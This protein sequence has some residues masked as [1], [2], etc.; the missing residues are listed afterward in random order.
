MRQVPVNDARK[1]VVL[2][3]HYVWDLRLVV[4]RGKDEVVLGLHWALHS[5]DIPVFVDS[6]ALK[7]FFHKKTTVQV[8]VRHFGNNWLVQLMHFNKY[9]VNL[10]L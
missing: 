9:M 7:R 2:I 6:R 5:T 4:L 3:I 10:K 8:Q 1:V